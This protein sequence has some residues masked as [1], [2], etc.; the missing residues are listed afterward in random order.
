M[1]IV[2]Y[3]SGKLW[4]C[5]GKRKEFLQ[6]Y[7]CFIVSC[8][9]TPN[10]VEYL[11]SIG[12][13]GPLTASA[14]ATARCL[15]QPNFKVFIALLRRIHF[16]RFPLKL[17]IFYF[18]PF[19]VANNSASNFTWRNHCNPQETFERRKTAA[20]RKRWHYT[21]RSNGWSKHGEYYCIGQ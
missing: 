20:W 12:T 13:T 19:S 15:V 6:N 18:P 8:R 7:K 5:V 14:I 1:L 11:S 17:I 4:N 2:L 3:H 9:L 10:I 21:S 16:N